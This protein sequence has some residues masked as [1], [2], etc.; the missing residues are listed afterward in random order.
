M[1]KTS[2]NAEYIENL[3]PQDKLREI[4]ERWTPEAKQPAFNNGDFYIEHG[5]SCN[6]LADFLA[7]ELNWAT[8]NR[9]FPIEISEQGKWNLLFTLESLSLV[10]GSNVLA[11]R[12][13][14]N[15]VE[16]RVLCSPWRSGQPQNYYD[17]ISNPATAENIGV[18]EGHDAP[19]YPRKIDSG[20]EINS[21]TVKENICESSEKA[22]GIDERVNM[23]NSFAPARGYRS[24][25]KTWGGII[26]MLSPF[27]SGAGHLSSSPFVKDIKYSDKAFLDAAAKFV[28][29]RKKTAE[30]YAAM[31]SALAEYVES[32]ENPPQK[33]QDGDLPGLIKFREAWNSQKYAGLFKF[34]D[35]DLWKNFDYIMQTYRVQDDSGS[36][37]GNTLSDPQSKPY[38]KVEDS[39]GSFC[40]VN[41]SR[42]TP[43]YSLVGQP[44]GQNQT[45]KL[46]W[47]VL[48]QRINS[49]KLDVA[50]RTLS[51]LD[52]QRE[53]LEAEFS[54]L[55][56]ICSNRAG[57]GDYERLRRE[58]GL[59]INGREP[60]QTF[61]SPDTVIPL[62]AGNCEVDIDENR[63]DK[64]ISEALGKTEEQIKNLKTSA[65]SKSEQDEHLRG[66]CLA[67]HTLVCVGTDLMEGREVLSDWSPDIYSTMIKQTMSAALTSDK[68]PLAWSKLREGFKFARNGRDIFNE[69]KLSMLSEWS[70]AENM[71]PTANQI[72]YTDACDGMSMR[73]LMLH[74]LKGT[75][76]RNGRGLGNMRSA[77]PP[78]L[79][80]WRMRNTFKEEAANLGRILTSGPEGALMSKYLS[81]SNQDVREARKKLVFFVTSFCD[82]FAKAAANSELNNWNREDVRELW[83][84]ADEAASRKLL[85]K[86]ASAAWQLD[87]TGLCVKMGASRPLYPLLSDYRRDSR[88][89]LD[90]LDFAYSSEKLPLYAELGL[91]DP[92]VYMRQARLSAPA[93]YGDLIDANSQYMP[94]LQIPRMPIDP[95]TGR[96]IYDVNAGNSDL[97]LF[98]REAAA[99]RTP[100]VLGS[101]EFGDL[102]NDIVIPSGME[103]F[104]NN[105]KKGY[106]SRKGAVIT[107]NLIRVGMAG[108]NAA[109]GTRA[110]CGDLG[111]NVNRHGFDKLTML[112]KS[113]Y[114]LGGVEFKQA[115][116]AEFN[117]EFQWG[118]CSNQVYLHH[119]YTKK[120]EVLKYSPLNLDYAFITSFAPFRRFNN[121]NLLFYTSKD[122]FLS[123]RSG[124]VDSL[125]FR[126]EENSFCGWNDAFGMYSVSYAKRPA[127]EP[128]PLLAKCINERLRGKFS[129]K[130]NAL[131]SE[132]GAE[133]YVAARS[134]VDGLSWNWESARM[135]CLT[136]NI[137]WDISEKEQSDNPSDS[138]LIMSATGM[139]PLMAWN[140]LMSD[141]EIINPKTLEYAFR[142]LYY[143]EPA[144]AAFRDVEG[145]YI[146]ILD[147]ISGKH[148]RKLGVWGA[149]QHEFLKSTAFLERRWD[150]TFKDNEDEMSLY[151]RDYC[152]SKEM[153]GFFTGAGQWG[154]L[155]SK[156]FN[157]SDEEL[158][159]ALPRSPYRTGESYD[160][161]GL[162]RAANGTPFGEQSEEAAK[163]AGVFLPQY[164]FGMEKLRIDSSYGE[165]AE[166]YRNER[167]SKEF[168]AYAPL[169]YF[170]FFQPQKLRNPSVLLNISNMVLK[171]YGVVP[172]KSDGSRCLYPS[173]A[174]DFEHAAL[175]AE[176][177]GMSLGAGVKNTPENLE[178]LTH[179]AKQNALLQLTNRLNALK[180][181]S[182]Y[183]NITKESTPML[184]EIYHDEVLSSVVRKSAA[185][186]E[187]M[188]DYF[189][190]KAEKDVMLKC[191][192]AGARELTGQTLSE[193]DNETKTIDMSGV[194]QEPPS[195]V[196]NEGEIRS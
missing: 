64:T 55:D 24:S 4:Y 112:N 60:T 124:S 126:G 118:Y 114:E 7:E 73:L 116:P 36:N 161:A 180:D 5:F 130:M 182:M 142:R 155:S 108:E 178:K 45:E 39:G 69:D 173:G 23:M 129:D 107:D 195:W 140:G 134:G 15:G 102:G 138:K 75:P 145:R 19:V 18:L 146:D 193:P 41:P 165:F 9:N 104:T 168:A 13:N 192:M 91:I 196:Y 94:L 92:R 2:G 62:D 25:S 143:G 157:P 79:L 167:N 68:D 3:L 172:L 86:R 186:L 177:N 6:F 17:A 191:L 184:Y 35:A 99:M 163:K 72:P 16:P 27:E 49:T 105:F 183:M 81:G 125:M 128:G 47:N 65:F 90:L 132:A 11:W 115:T 58:Y 67:L 100:G 59:K 40:D 77:F 83:S 51:D 187:K 175:L 154:L 166:W 30:L 144:L 101:F 169:T 95:A 149:W 139:N 189:P 136:E 159:K 63:V 20:A 103:L 147:N 38:D 111:Q 156:C 43:K 179:S 82:S 194:S 190:D 158:K 50:I 131:A 56:D 123:N 87:G 78:R 37:I 54:A 1:P 48:N 76:M 85:L 109:L 28:S 12:T 89:L 80:K 171:G 181:N 14:E 46:V 44:L 135:R 88:P 26:T 61:F 148:R 32:L 106:L 185:D 120:E 113:D 160:D 8:E 53:D 52:R 84:R 96:T 98:L 93:Y 164:K 97:L 21:E 22:S 57:V 152:V 10:H 151:P 121:E 162:L 150:T 174:P 119:I 127:A 31:E 137:C 33:P 74:G 71:L 153:K 34:L 170:N 188:P 42:G 66:L 122:G 117:A 176:S 29:K 70:T 141:K 110:F 133:R